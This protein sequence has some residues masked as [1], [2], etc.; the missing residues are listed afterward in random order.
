MLI[1]YALNDRDLRAIGRPSKR[2]KSG[3]MLQCSK[4]SDTMIE[5]LRYHGD[6]QWDIRFHPNNPWPTQM[7]ELGEIP[8]PPYI[9]R[10]N[11]PELED[12]QNYQTVFNKQPGSAAAPTAS[13]HFT[14]ELLQQLVDKGVERHHLTHHVGSGTFL[15]V[16]VDNIEEHKMHLEVSHVPAKTSQS[17]ALAKKEGRPII[18][19]GTTVV[20]AL[21]S[22]ATQILKG[23]SYQGQTD[24][25]IYPPYQYKVVDH[26]ITNFHLPESTL[27]MLVSAL[28]GREHLMNAYSEAV[29][30]KY[31]FFS[32]GDAMYIRP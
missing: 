7:E 32:Y 16:R 30:E 8:L 13:L 25:F 19:V 26:L 20:R 2:L 31:R 18:A 11:G 23:E 14:E 9:E 15:P 5:L 12:L 4:K 3:E 1:Q 21:E 22:G 29:Q 27:L 17:I 28:I 10:E 6:G 24:L